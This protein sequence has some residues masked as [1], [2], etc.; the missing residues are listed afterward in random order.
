MQ[1]C[2]FGMV[3]SGYGH[4]L[5]SR[6]VIVIT[7]PRNYAEL[8]AYSRKNR[9]YELNYASL[10]QLWPFFVIKANYVLQRKQRSHFCDY[11]TSVIWATEPTLKKYNQ[12][13]VI[14]NQTIRRPNHNFAL[15][16]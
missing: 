3:Y 13:T 12:C 9:N 14:I 2:A 6:V 10:R 4:N 15:T 8:R 1:C 7:T 5:H 11:P 16:V